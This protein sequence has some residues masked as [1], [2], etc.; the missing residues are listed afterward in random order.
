MR[1]G[2][3]WHSNFHSFDSDFPDS[4]IKKFYPML[5]FQ[6]LSKRYRE[7]AAKKEGEAM[8]TARQ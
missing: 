7:L 4:F 3:V 5:N 1:P 6:L 2:I 8:P